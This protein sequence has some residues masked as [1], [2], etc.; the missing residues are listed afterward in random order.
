MKPTF[1][2]TPFED[3]D[4]VKK[5][6]ARW[7]AE[8]CKWFV[9]AGVDLTPFFSWLPAELRAQHEAEAK[10]LSLVAASVSTLNP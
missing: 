10:S 3:K 9:P 2:N 7:N 6:G 1:L 5:L 4:R 8:R